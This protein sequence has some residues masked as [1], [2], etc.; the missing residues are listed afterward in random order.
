MSQAEQ[1]TLKMI[2]KKSRRLTEKLASGVDV[3]LVRVV[4]QRQVEKMAERFI[5]ISDYE[6]PSCDILAQPAEQPNMW[7]SSDLFWFKCCLVRR[8]PS[9]VRPNFM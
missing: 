1:R 6:R 4:L 8:D 9:V 2:H 7:F 3:R 5:E